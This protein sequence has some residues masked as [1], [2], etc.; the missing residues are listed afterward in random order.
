MQR[1]GVVIVMMVLHHTARC[2]SVRITVAI[3]LPQEVAII[4]ANTNV[5]RVVVI[6]RNH[7][8]LHI[9]H[10]TVVQRQAAII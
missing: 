10:P 4:V 2:I 1:V 9:V 7:I 6:M 8:L 3:M 5:K